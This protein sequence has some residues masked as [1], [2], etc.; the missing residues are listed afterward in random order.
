MKAHSASCTDVLNDSLT[1]VATDAVG[2]GGAN[3][4]WEVRTEHG[5]VVASVQ[6]QNGPR[7]EPGSI[8]GVT[9]AAM[10]ALLLE[11]LRQFQA[12]PY[13]SRETALIVT[14]LE[15]VLDLIHRRTR[16]RAS[17]GVLGKNER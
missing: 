14:K 17:R 9:H 11:P 13:P 4:H 5:D 8:A 16:E 10:V 6:F 7:G 2:S 1:I 15:E 12:G 3:H